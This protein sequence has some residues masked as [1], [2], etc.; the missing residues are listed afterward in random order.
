MASNTSSSATLS[1]ALR[2]CPPREFY[3]GRYH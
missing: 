3:M 1:K 2:S